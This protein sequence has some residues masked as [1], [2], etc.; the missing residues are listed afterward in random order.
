[1]LTLIKH[2]I[3]AKKSFRLMSILA[4]HVV[5]TVVHLQYFSFELLSYQ[6]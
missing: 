3:S 2:V 6:F 1:M 4:Q 5:I